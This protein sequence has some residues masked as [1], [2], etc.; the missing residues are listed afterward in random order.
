MSWIDIAILICL[1]VFCISFGVLM[2][3]FARMDVKSKAT[4][5]YDRARDKYI[6]RFNLTPEKKQLYEITEE[7]LSS[8]GI[9]FRMGANFSPF[10]YMVLRILFALL[11]G[12]LG[13]LIE[14]ILILPLAVAGYY[15]VAWYFKHEDKYDNGEM[16]E[17]IGNMYGIVAIQL[18]NSV[19]LADVIYECAL[20]VKYKRLKQALLELNMEYKQFADIRAAADSFRRKFNNEHIDM[21]AKTIEQ[22]ENSGDA[23]ELFRDMESQISGINE[24]LN[25]RKERKIKAVADIFMV[26]I[27]IGAVLFMAYIMV[28]MFSETTVFL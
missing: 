6:D 20:A 3:Y 25:M 26:L 22:A 21:F 7:K 1:F 4:S 11:F 16:L 8:R 18:K 28:L 15:V 27:F 24:A 13:M 5:A 12:F 14:P 10:D 2:G 19:Y 23:V 17:D 9:K